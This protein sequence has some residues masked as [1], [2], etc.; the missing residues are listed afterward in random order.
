MQVFVSINTIEPKAT[1]PFSYLGGAGIL[2]VLVNYFSEPS[3]VKIIFSNEKE[4]KNFF[5]YHVEQKY[6]FP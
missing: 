6:I 2:I 3:S 5:S 4:S 1:Q